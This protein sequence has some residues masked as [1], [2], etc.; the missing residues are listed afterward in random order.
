MGWQLTL[1][2]LCPHAMSTNTFPGVSAVSLTLNSPV[3][4]RLNTVTSA[5]WGWTVLGPT[6]WTW[7]LDGSVG[8]LQPDKT[9]AP[10][11]KSVAA[12]LVGMIGPIFHQRSGWTQV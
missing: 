8:P 3:F 9:R 1:S 7:L 11:M 5:V 10:T 12:R 2:G 6:V 4:V